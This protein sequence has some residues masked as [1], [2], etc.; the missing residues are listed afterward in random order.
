MHD[1]WKYGGEGGRVI[2]G[3]SRCGCS[4][5]EGGEG[6]REFSRMK[7]AE[8]CD[9]LYR[10]RGGG[11]GRRGADNLYLPRCGV[12]VEVHTSCAC[13]AKEIPCSS[14]TR[15]ATLLYT[16][17]SK[18]YVPIRPLVFTM[19]LPRWSGFCIQRAKAYTMHVYLTRLHVSV[20][21]A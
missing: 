10:G 3:V 15:L 13:G 9:F 19:A 12:Y 16:S 7:A 14:L 2:K 8:A 11:G 21:R 6:S 18:L 1:V 20:F 17:Y 5:R 4:P